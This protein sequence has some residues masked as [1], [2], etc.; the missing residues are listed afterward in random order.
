[1]LFCVKRFICQSLEAI[2]Q[3]PLIER[4]EVMEFT[5]DLMREPTS[6]C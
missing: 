2:R 6:R 3:M 5:L 4:L 1:L